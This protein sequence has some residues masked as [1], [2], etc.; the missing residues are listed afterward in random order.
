MA[1]RNS[2]RASIV[3]VDVDDTLVR[4]F[5]TRQIPILNAIRYVRAMFD[6]GNTLYL[7]S[8]GG[9]DY[10]KEIAIKLK[11]EDCFVGFLPKPEI[12]LDD[13]LVNLLDHCEFLHPSNVDA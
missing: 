5:G 7:W 10:S 6:A 8:R 9:A 11:I 2:L 3:F 12:V 4:S 13:R 1:G